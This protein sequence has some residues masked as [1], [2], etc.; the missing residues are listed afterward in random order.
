MKSLI[1]TAVGRA[2]TLLSLGLQFSLKPP[3]IKLDCVVVFQGRPS[4]HGMSKDLEKML[5][6]FI[7]IKRAFLKNV[8]KYNFIY[9]IG[10]HFGKVKKL[11]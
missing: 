7:K 10:R 5:Q 3:G 8:N 11:A 1:E 4:G 9:F 2:L 6:M